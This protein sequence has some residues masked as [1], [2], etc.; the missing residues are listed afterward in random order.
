MEYFNFCAVTTCNFEILKQQTAV[1]F[2]IYFADI[3]SRKTAILKTSIR[4]FTSTF[5]MINVNSLAPGIH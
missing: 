1:K 5:E 3:F 2:H 4:K